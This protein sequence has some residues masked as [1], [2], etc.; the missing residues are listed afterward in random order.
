MALT[1]PLVLVSTIRF[2]AL[3]CSLVTYPTNRSEGKL[4]GAPVESRLQGGGSEFSARSSVRKDTLPEGTQRPISVYTSEFYDA[5]SFFYRLEN[6][7]YANLPLKIF[8]K[9]SF[10]YHPFN[11]SSLAVIPFLNDRCPFRPST[12]FLLPLAPTF[13]TPLPSTRSTLLAKSVQA[14]GAI[15]F[16]PVVVLFLTAICS[17]ICQSSKVARNLRATS[18]F[19]SQSVIGYADVK[20]TSR[21]TKEEQLDCLTM[22]FAQ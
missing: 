9:C 18:S 8:H 3:H 10:V 17:G 4:W 5:N 16:L 6:R 11:R 14:I 20:R 12:P 19:P 21:I 13:R 15:I 7:L 22:K 1:R 2:L